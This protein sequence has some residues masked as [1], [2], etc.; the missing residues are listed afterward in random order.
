MKKRLLSLISAMALCFTAMPSYAVAEDT[1]DD[2]YE[3][4]L[5]LS[6]SETHFYDDDDT[7]TYF[8]VDTDYE[9][10]TITLVDAD[11]LTEYTMMDDGKFSISGDDLQNDG[12]YTTK[13]ELDTTMTSFSKE[14]HFY[15]VTENGSNYSNTV[16]IKITK[17][18]TDAQIK[19]MA[20]VD[21]AISTLQS[22]KNYKSAS[23]N[24]RV[25]ML[26]ELLSEL[27]ENGIPSVPRSQ[28]ER[29]SVCFP[30]RFPFF[31]YIVRL[32]VSR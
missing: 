23:N 10:E 1:N 22:T 5:I 6:C 2:I 17:K 11:T 28:S 27:A 4:E 30:Y 31:I 32:C 24:E 19:E 9:G 8:Y 3:Y 29:G 15:A 18:I 25:T 7:L 12:V 21:E 13:I 26:Y 14:Y 16:T 20:A